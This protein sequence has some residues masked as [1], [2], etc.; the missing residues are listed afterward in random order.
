VIRLWNL[1]AFD[2]SAVGV[3]RRRQMELRHWGGLGI[4]IWVTTAQA[5]QL[6]KYGAGGRLLNRLR[7]L[8]FCSGRAGPH[9]EEFGS[10]TTLEEVARARAAVG[11]KIVADGADFAVTRALGRTVLTAMKEVDR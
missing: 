2:S 4:G 5:A 3:M 7:Y 10:E 8:T 1:A 6:Y 11:L 9:V